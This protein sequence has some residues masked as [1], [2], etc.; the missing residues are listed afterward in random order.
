LGEK[1]F[2]G[3]CRNWV[4]GGGGR[5]LLCEKLKEGQF[6]RLGQRNNSDL[7]LNAKDGDGDD[8]EPGKN[9]S[10]FSTIYII[11]PATLFKAVTKITSFGFI[12]AKKQFS[13]TRNC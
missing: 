6:S 8:D 7:S 10:S 5:G 13:H 12:V 1:I 9:L 2:I 4:G 3:F 11:L